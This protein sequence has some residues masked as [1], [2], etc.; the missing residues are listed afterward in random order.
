MKDHGE[1]RED[2]VHTS[3]LKIGVAFRG[4]AYSGYLAITKLVIIKQ[5]VV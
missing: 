5:Y 4:A 2:Q 1:I 3:S